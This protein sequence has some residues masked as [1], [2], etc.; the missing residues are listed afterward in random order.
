MVRTTPHHLYMS[1]GPVIKAWEWVSSLQCKFFIIQTLFLNHTQAT[2]GALAI[3]HNQ[4]V[5]F[6]GKIHSVTLEVDAPIND[7]HPMMMA[8][9]RNT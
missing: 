6:E 2:G 3:I 5:P 4:L 1:N 8:L 7:A 9:S